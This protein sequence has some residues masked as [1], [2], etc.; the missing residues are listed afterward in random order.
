MD[1]YAVVKERFRFPNAMGFFEV[2]D[3]N[4]RLGAFAVI[5]DSNGCRWAFDEAQPRAISE[6]EIRSRG[7]FA[8]KPE[9]AYDLIDF[10]ENHYSQPSRDADPKILCAPMPGLTPPPTVSANDICH[11]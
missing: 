9:D 6:T 2:P 5:C 1:Y 3:D 11:E 4:L 7:G 10:S 8:V